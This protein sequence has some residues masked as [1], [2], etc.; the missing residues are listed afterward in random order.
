MDELEELV[1]RLRKSPATADTLPSTSYALIRAF[2]KAGKYDE[3]MRILN[4][5][6]NY[7][8]F[9]DH[10]VANILMDEFLKQGN[11]RGNTIKQYCDSIILV[12]F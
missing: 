12:I 9:L 2:M 5:R 11:H 4:D 8:V 6:W 3:L 1:H 10:H 7:G